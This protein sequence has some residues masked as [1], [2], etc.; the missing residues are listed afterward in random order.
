MNAPVPV[1]GSW[2]KV[3]RVTSL[4]LIISLLAF[5]GSRLVFAVWWPMHPL[6][7]ALSC[8][9]MV[10]LAAS[11]RFAA[12]RRNWRIGVIVYAI[13]SQVLP[14]VVREPALLLPIVGGLIPIAIL[15]GSLVALSKKGDAPR[16]SQGS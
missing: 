14:M 16:R 10:L 11:F 6:D 5:I 2:G 7:F 12:H 9:A 3:E 4:F 13:A 1:A 8:V 15:V